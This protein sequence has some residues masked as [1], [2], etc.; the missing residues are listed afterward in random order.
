MKV[1]DGDPKMTTIDNKVN[2]MAY[3]QELIK[4]TYRKGWNLPDMPTF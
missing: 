2:A 3:A 4:H 1:I